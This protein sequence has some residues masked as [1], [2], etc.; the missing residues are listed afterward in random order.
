LTLK[1]IERPV[2]AFVLRLDPDAEAVGHNELRSVGKE[3]KPL[4]ALPDKPS[5]AEAQVA[6]PS[7][8]NLRIENAPALS[9]AVL[10]FANLG[11]NP[12]EDY[13]AEAITEDLTIDLSCIPDALVIARHSAAAFKDKLV[14]V[15]QVGEELGVRYVVEGSVRKLG[16][17][18][19]VTA[20]LISTEA[21]TQMWAGRFDQNVKDIGIG[22]EEIVSRL[23]A[24]L[25]VQMVDAESVRSMRERPDNPDASD[26]I[27]RGA[28][29]VRKTSDP[30]Q[31]SRVAELFEQ[32][33]HLDPRSVRAM[34][35]LVSGLI[36][37]Y[38][39]PD[40]PDRGN[41]AFLERAASLVS[42]AVA[43]EPDSG[44]VL[45]ALASLQRAQGRWAEALATFQRVVEQ[46]PNTPAAY[47]QLGFLRLAV[48]NAVEAISSLQQSI[49]VDPLSPWNPHVYAR[50]GLA[51]LMLGRDE[52]SIEWQQRALAA[53][54]SQP[55]ARRA[56]SY[57]FIASAFAL[58]GKLNEAHP[59]LAEA[60]RLWPFATVR[61]L[62]P[63]ISPR[64]LPPP[65]YL[66]QMR[67]VQEGLRLA[68]LRD[69]ADEEAD[70]G[71]VSDGNLHADLIGVTPIGVPGATTIRTHELANL[72][73][74][75]KPILI[76]VALDSWARSLPEAI[77]LQGT[78]HGA[79]FPGTV[80]NRFRHKMQN[81]M[82]GNLSAPIVVFGVNAERFT[83]Y[84]LS[85]RLVSLGYDNV[86]WYRGGVEAWQVNG[87][88]ET[89]LT[90]QDW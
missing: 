77:G 42:A 72:L 1:N 75:R 25:G 89:D 58:I 86:F 56:Q 39:I 59:S 57:L 14:N 81:L 90:L 6:L 24:V 64:G 34:C 78:G 11:G 41:E 43:I 37:R 27:L 53:G 79:S 35:A 88:P 66:E 7:P 23:R 62:L 13:L 63:I 31:L 51:L 10:P 49:R 19:R 5:L 85:L 28:S 60:N 33:L 40:Y 22:Q 87:L 54:G 17:V 38:V 9:L 65:A 69:H 52:E 30:S 70:I 16:D 73:E 46:N 18:L 61:S 48:G 47:R 68:G 29:A 15:R 36:D 82:Q 71:V 50:I 32:A 80:E 21:D 55:A 45:F 74:G 2:E 26:L 8:P 83:G 3:Q 12:N 67:H 4:L 20:R 76:D 44:R 84:N